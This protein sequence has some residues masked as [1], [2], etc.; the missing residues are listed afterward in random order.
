V[1]PGFCK[2]IKVTYLPP[3]RPLH[4]TSGTHITGWESLHY[5]LYKTQKHGVFSKRC[6]PSNV[7]YEID[8]H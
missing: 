7:I 1:N 8:V 6:F 4:T 2:K 5:M 3:G